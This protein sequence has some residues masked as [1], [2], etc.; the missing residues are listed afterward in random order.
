MQLKNLKSYFDNIYSNELNI[1][2]IPV[3]D[4]E[5]DQEFEKPLLSCMGRD[6]DLNAKRNH[7]KAVKWFLR[8]VSDNYYKCQLGH[9]DA[10]CLCKRSRSGENA[11]WRFF[12]IAEHPKY[13]ELEIEIR[14]ELFYKQTGILLEGNGHEQIVEFS[15]DEKNKA[16]LKELN[17]RIA[18][19]L[20]D[21]LL[22]DYAYGETEGY[23]KDKFNLTKIEYEEL[24][25][26]AKKR[27][28]RKQPMNDKLQDFILENINE[29]KL[30]GGD[31]AKPSIGKGSIDYRIIFMIKETA[32]AKRLDYKT[33]K[34][35]DN[36]IKTVCDKINSWDYFKRVSPTAGGK[37]NTPE[38]SIKA[39][40]ERYLA[41]HPT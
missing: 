26:I 31:S 14:R 21:Q 35:T 37:G 15:R 9:C 10:G 34:N 6:I 32:V 24:I 20:I 23:T 19:Y 1:L 38:S 27:H 28:S 25:S 3:I 13:H 4:L 11:Y 40:R 29:N 7:R 18:E 33:I 30:K 22:V 12:D 8:E 17:D 16:A 41:K 5:K 39:V 2:T 36:V